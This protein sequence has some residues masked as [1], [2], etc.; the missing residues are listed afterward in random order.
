MLTQKLRCHKIKFD[1]SLSG[2]VALLPVTFFLCEEKK[3]ANEM[4]ALGVRGRIK[5]DKGCFKFMLMDNFSSA[6]IQFDKKN[7]FYEI[8]L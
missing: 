2:L 4:S 7:L 6:F 1:V 8:R 3:M 5:F